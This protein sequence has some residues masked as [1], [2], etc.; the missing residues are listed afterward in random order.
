MAEQEPIKPK[1]PRTM[2]RAGDPH[3]QSS[4][5]E[6][7]A[8][9]TAVEQFKELFQPTATRIMLDQVRKRR[10]KYNDTADED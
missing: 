1:K 3:D 9:P 8:K 10:L 7:P 6:F 5:E 2:I 4:Y